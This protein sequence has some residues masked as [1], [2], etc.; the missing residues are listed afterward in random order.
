LG[1]VII[2]I[3]LVLDRRVFKPQ[4]LPMFV[5]IEAVVIGGI[6]WLAVAFP[7]RPMCNRL[8]LLKNSIFLKNSGNFEDREC[9]VKLRTSL[10]ALPSAIFSGIFWRL[11]FSTATRT[12]LTRPHPVDERYGLI[13]TVFR[14]KL[15]SVVYKGLH[16]H[17][18]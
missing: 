2:L 10:V 16:G 4:S 1:A 12:T 13:T 8:W 11:S 18:R 7:N 6:I 17:S 15:N 9:L 3:N 5:A 14:N